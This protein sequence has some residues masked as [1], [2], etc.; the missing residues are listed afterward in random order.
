MSDERL[1]VLTGG[2]SMEERQQ[3]LTDGA[4][5]LAGEKRR[6]I[7]RLA[8]VVRPTLHCTRRPPPCVK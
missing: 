5:T 7:L 6:S 3:R 4:E 8:N 1:T 2:P